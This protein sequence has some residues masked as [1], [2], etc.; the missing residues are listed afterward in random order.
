MN[1]TER[2]AVNWLTKQG[3][4]QNSIKH[5]INPDFVVDGKGYE[6]KRL[7]EKSI[8]FTS[9][10]MR[11]F[12]KTNPIVLIFSDA[13]EPIIVA[14]F[15]EVKKRVSIYV[16]PNEIIKITDE[17]KHILDTLKV[18]TRQPYHEVLQIV[19]EPLTIPS[20]TKK[21]QKQILKKLR[22]LRSIVKKR[23]GGK[24]DEKK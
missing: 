21:E 8:F 9:Q 11:E 10:Q 1:K 14:P 18:H 5:R 22:H 13:E 24:K 15:N 12:R 3:I 6:V 17:Q 4:P 20:Y 7:H 2:K 19:L 23:M 16:L